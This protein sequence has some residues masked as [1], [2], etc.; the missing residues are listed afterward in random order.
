MFMFMIVVAIVIVIVIV[1]VMIMVMVIMSIAD[2]L[3]DPEP[4]Y[5]VPSNTSQSTQLLQRILEPVFQFVGDDQ[6]EF[7]ARISDQWY[8]GQEDQDGNDDRGQWIPEIP[9]FPEREDGAE[10]DGQRTSCVG[11]DV[12]VNSVHVL[13]SM[14]M[15][16]VVPVIMSVIMSV[17]R[18]A[19]S[20]KTHHV[21]Q[22][23]QRAHDQQ[24]LHMSQ[25]FAFH[26]SLNGFPDE[27]DRNQHEEDAVSKSGEDVQFA[28]AKRH[29]RGCRP[30]GGDC[31]AET[32]D[33]GQAVEKHVDCIAEETERAAD[34]AVKRLHQHEAKVQTRKV[35]DTAGVAFAEDAVEERA[36][37]AA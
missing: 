26:N 30:F 6:E 35:C 32:N 3:F 12:Q 34:P 22:K 14:A 1:V 11:R 5:R 16:V 24:L 4:R 20:E 7:A 17:M 25:L 27:F 23:A 8:G 29:L 36:R 2:F 9:G 19:K 37:L 18:V 31:C 33:E 13:I 10:D 15:A 28:P 21:D